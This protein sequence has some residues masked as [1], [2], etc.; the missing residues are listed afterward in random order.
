MLGFVG[1]FQLL[2]CRRSTHI[3]QKPLTLALCA[4]LTMMQVV[5]PSSWSDIGV[6]EQAF[7]PLNTRL[8]VPEGWRLNK[9]G[10]TSTT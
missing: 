1:E 4:P 9:I 8:W 5:Y 6:L 3:S 7:H 2:P 10:F